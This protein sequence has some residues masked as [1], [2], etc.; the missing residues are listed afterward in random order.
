ME[1]KTFIFLAGVHRSGTSLLHEIIRE[2]PAISGFSDTG[3]HEDEGQHLQSVYEPAKSFGGPGRFVFD[4]ESYMDESHSL[5]TIENANL[6]FEQWSEYYN[7]E[8]DYLIEKSPP[9]IIRTRFLKKLYPNCKFVVILRHPIAVAYA[10]M[11]WSK[12][13]IS[14]LLEHTV[15]AYEIF[16]KDMPYL[17]DSVYVVRYEEFVLMPQKVINDI[18]HFIGL[19]AIDIRHSIHSDV[20]NKYFSMWETDRKKLFSRIS[21]GVTSDFEARANKCGYSIKNYNDLA[22]VTWLASRNKS[23]NF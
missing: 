20:N 11:K 12:T 3:V 14:S 13:S 18:Y 15:L 22:P 5:A 1:N 17:D 9:N 8:S 10:T 6:L 19:N 2:H 21:N 23:D 16:L 7:L 4:T